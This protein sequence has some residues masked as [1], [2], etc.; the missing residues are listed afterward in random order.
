MN[1]GKTEVAV[2]EDTLANAIHSTKD[3]RVQVLQ[4]DVGNAAIFRTLYGDDIRYCYAYR[5]WFVWDGKRFVIDDTGE[6]QRKA[7]MTT[8]RLWRGVDKFSDPDRRDSWKKHAKRTESAYRIKSM[9]E[10]A[11]S[12]QGT[13]VTPHK[14][15][16]EP[17]LL[18]VENGTLDLKTG[19]L[20]AHSRKDLITKI[21]PVPYD[22]EAVCPTWDK[23]LDE[24][25][26]GDPDLIRFLQKAVGYSLTGDTGEQVLFILFGTGANGKSTFINTILHL[27]GDYGL[28]TPTETLLAKKH[29]TGIP[30]DLARLKGARFV[31]AVEAEQGRPLAEALVKQLTGGDPVAARFLYGEYFQFY[32]TFKLFLSVNHRPV[33]KGS[34]HGIWRRI[35]LIPFNVTFRL[36]KRDPDLSTKLKAEL[37]GILRWAVEGCLLW[38]KEGLEPPHAVEAATE[39]YRSDMDV[40]GDFIRDCCEEVSDAKTPFKDL[41]AKYTTWSLANGDVFPDQ[42]EFAQALSERGF[43]PGKNKALGRF[44]WGIRITSG[45]AKGDG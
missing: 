13:A 31:A 35:R 42:K 12:E 45:D 41:F 10:L 40:V 2:S 23:F 4:T 29:G 22:K 7:K 43:A 14:L 16:I 32:P 33:I 19:L 18:N 27:L 28:Q 3:A 17:W 44:R 39:D 38:Q 37:P 15:D 8:N 26:P 11:Q 21:A 20:R 6:I 9:I 25:M 24:I 36:G 30:N 1:V 34:D 5:K